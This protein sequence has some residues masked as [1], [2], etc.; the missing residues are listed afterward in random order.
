MNVLTSPWFKWV[1][2]VAVVVASVVAWNSRYSSGYSAGLIA[3]VKQQQQADKEALAAANDRYRQ[4]EQQLNAKLSDLAS[5][6]A[7]ELARVNAS[8]DAARRSA[9]AFSVRL[10]QV[11][12]ILRK[13]ATSAGADPVATGASAR[14]T[15]I[16]LAELL[17]KSVERSRQLAGYADDARLA[18][19]LCEQQYDQV[20]NTVNDQR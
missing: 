3:G 4:L 9:D 14:D 1:V 16:L 12:G 13:S 2:L 11:T 7:E 8:R 20:R 18:G 19:Q 5:Q 17:G 10:N 6:H 15:A